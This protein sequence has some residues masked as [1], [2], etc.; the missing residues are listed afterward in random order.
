MSRKKKIL[1]IFHLCFA[2]TYLFWLLIQP[3]V[4]EI[5]AQ[6]SKCALFEA[7]MEK[8]SLFQQL[9][10]VD[11]LT[12]LEGYTTAN[13]KKSPS[14]LQEVGSLFF[15]DTP[16]F[17]L[18]WLF[19]SLAI[20]S[21]LLFRI[22]GGVVSVWLLPLIVLGYAYFFYD[23]PQKSRETLFPSEGYVLTTYVETAENKARGRRESLLLGWHRYLVCEWACEEPSQD[24]ALFKE[25]LDKGLFAFNVARLKWILEG[26][27][28]E[29]VLAGFA[30]SPSLLRIAS[31]FIWNLFFA[32]FINRR[33]KNTSIAAPSTL[34]C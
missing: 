32:W 24:P 7:V 28:D 11:Q 27:G 23:V 20:C 13:Q 3:Y 2:F 5:I 14:L 4:K 25:Q 26:K 30:A 17:A 10:S 15:V 29:I 31:Y 12:L 33:E 9:P 6:K 8:E 18:A 16:P 34:T 21:L 1:I 19:F 22:E